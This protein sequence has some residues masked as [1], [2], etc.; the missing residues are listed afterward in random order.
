MEMA[1]F[2][3]LLTLQLMVNYTLYDTYHLTPKSIFS[4]FDY[5][6]NITYSSGNLSHLCLNLSF[7]TAWLPLTL[8]FGDT[9]EWSGYLAEINNE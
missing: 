3:T 5:K 7:Y 8:Q 1:T 2:H 4:N 9:P 6:Y